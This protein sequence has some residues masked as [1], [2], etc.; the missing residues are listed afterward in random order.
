MIKGTSGG[1]CGFAIS[2]GS[3]T[4]YLSINLFDSAIRAYDYAS[5]TWLTSELSYGGITNYHKV[6]LEI[7]NNECAVTVYNES[8]TQLTTASF[9]LPS[10]YQNTTVYPCI[11]TYTANKTTYF[12]N[13]MIKPL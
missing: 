3:G 6:K 5:G 13:L 9:T 2:K 7:T 4:N 8:G 11:A 10:N 1:V 12:K